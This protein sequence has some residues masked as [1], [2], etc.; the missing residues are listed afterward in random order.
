MYKNRY[1]LV[2]VAMPVIVCAAGR[3]RI[4]LSDLAARV[5]KLV[6][7]QLKVSKELEVAI[8]RENEKLVRLTNMKDKLEREKKDLD[9]K[10][11]ARGLPAVALPDRNAATHRRDT[12]VQP[13]QEVSD[14]HRIVNEMSYVIKELSA[15]ND[16]FA[17][18]KDALD[19]AIKQQQALKD[20]IHYL[21]Q[22]KQLLSAGL[23]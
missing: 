16:V 11:V 4:P 15:Q 12:V 19:Q 13:V 8:E 3:G 6:D 21:S 1:V 17:A 10:R 22:Y 20:D 18:R 14:A 7:E 9:A 23:N 5:P 2:L